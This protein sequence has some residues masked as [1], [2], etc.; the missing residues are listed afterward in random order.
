MYVRVGQVWPSRQDGYGPQLYAY[1]RLEANRKMLD[2]LCLQQ[3]F[4]FEE[5]FPKPD[6]YDPFLQEILDQERRE[7]AEAGKGRK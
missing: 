4:T 6:G 7:A 1:R 3:N 5:L 2:R